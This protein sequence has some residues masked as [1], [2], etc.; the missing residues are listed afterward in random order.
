MADAAS[1][2]ETNR[3]YRVLQQT[4]SV[5]AALRDGYG[6]RAKATEIALL[7]CAAIFC[8]VTFAGEGLYADLSVGARTGRLV[9]GIASV[10]AF[11]ASLAILVVDWKGS[12]ARHGEAAEKW[13]AVLEEFRGRRLGIVSW[14][15]EERVAPNAVYRNAGRYS[16]GIPEKTFNRLNAWH[17]RK[18]EVSKLLSKYPGCPRPILS[19]TVRMLDTKKALR[20]PDPGVQGADGA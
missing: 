12:A 9:L 4:M 18:V 16:V 20:R 3:Q 11:A 1:A 14:L 2:R 10:L 19:L 13:T 17:L 7:I 5:H 15:V 6:I 8:A